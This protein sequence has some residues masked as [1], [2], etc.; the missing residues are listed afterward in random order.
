M[1]NIL[2]HIFITK[3]KCCTYLAYVCELSAFLYQRDVIFTW[4]AAYV[5]LTINMGQLQL[6]TIHFIKL[7][8]E[9]NSDQ[10]ILRRFLYKGVS[11][12]IY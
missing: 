11:P 1:H 3:E 8:S 9:I 5:D 10:I 2:A 4:A 12:K 7:E 6:P